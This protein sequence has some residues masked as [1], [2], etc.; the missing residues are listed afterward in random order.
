MLPLRM[1]DTAGAAGWC[2]LPIAD[3][4]GVR[5]DDGSRHARWWRDMVER[6]IRAKDKLVQRIGSTHRAF[7]SQVG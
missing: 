6:P 4:K 5:R 7:A 2:G 1:G 3:P